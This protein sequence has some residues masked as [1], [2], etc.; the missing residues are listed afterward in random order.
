MDAIAWATETF[1]PMNLVW[2][3]LPPVKKYP[4]DTHVQGLTMDKVA[5]IDL[6]LTNKAIRMA[7]LITPINAA[8]MPL[9]TYAIAAIAGTD[10]TQAD[11]WLARILSQL[12]TQRVKEIQATL[13]Q[14]RG[15]AS[16]TTI[17]VFTLQL[18]A[19]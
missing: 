5:G 13:K 19:R 4:N 18:T 17:G 15:I 10:K 7:T 11:M 12:K 6:V 14:I 8:Y 16:I 3:P 2:S 9:C 1:A